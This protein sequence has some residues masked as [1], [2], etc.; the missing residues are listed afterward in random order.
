VDPGADAMKKLGLNGK[1]FACSTEPMGHSLE[2]WGARL[3][4]FDVMG[5]GG[6]MHVI[7]DVYGKH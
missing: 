2:E 5:T 4:G 6:C 7:I 1:V 3:G